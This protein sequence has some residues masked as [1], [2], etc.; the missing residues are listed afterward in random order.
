MNFHT[1]PKLH[2]GTVLFV[3]TLLCQHYIYRTCN[4]GPIT[5]HMDNS[6]LTL[7]LN[8]NDSIS[9]IYLHS[10]TIGLL[11]S[12]ITK[13]I[14]DF[15]FL[16]CLCKQGISVVFQ[17]KCGGADFPALIIIIVIE[18]DKRA[19]TACWAFERNT[20]PPVCQF[21]L[22]KKPHKQHQILE[23]STSGIPTFY[24]C[25]PGHEI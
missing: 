16:H 11:G 12:Q 13:K 17:E 23:A 8:S 15:I 5:S 22:Q 24:I 25:L 3:F 18:G 10:V 21:D 7:E 6:N 20:S 2:I 9:T 1:Y 4:F 14:V 19:T